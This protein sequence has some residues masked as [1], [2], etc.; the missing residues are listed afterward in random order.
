MNNPFEPPAAEVA[1]PANAPMPPAVQRACTLVLLALALGVVTLLPG[2]RPPEPEE[3]PFGFTLAVIVFFGGITVALVQVVRRG[4]NWGRW[5]LLAYLV[6]GW[7]LML[8][9]LNEDFN[10]S[11]LLGF[12]DIISVAME[13]VAAV[14]LFKGAS[15]RWFR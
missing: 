3:V 5:A 12:L 4:R 1:D 7:W 8:D 10:A 15:A 11:P 14:L 2:I 13:V 6:L 9:Q